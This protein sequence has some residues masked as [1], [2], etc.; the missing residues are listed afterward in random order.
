MTFQNS[1]NVG[2]P[3]NPIVLSS[4]EKLEGD[5]NEDGSVDVADIDLVIEQIDET[6]N[7]TNKAADVNDDGKINVADVDYII[8]RIV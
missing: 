5:A 3:S 6:V 4:K 2:E 8:E 7:E 1:A